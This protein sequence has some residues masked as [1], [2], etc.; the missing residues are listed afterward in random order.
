MKT[1][2]A[3]KAVKKQPRMTPAQQSK[4]F[5]ETARKLD[6]DERP[7]AFDRVMKRAAAKK[8]K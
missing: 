3:R 7:E 1:T 5:I 2:T 6:A 8:T 4:A